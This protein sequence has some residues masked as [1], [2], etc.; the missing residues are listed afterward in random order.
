MKKY[1]AILFVFIMMVPIIAFAEQTNI[2]AHNGIAFG[3][4]KEEIESIELANGFE[5]HTRV[6]YKGKIAGQENAMVAFVFNDEKSCPASDVGAGGMFW[7]EYAFGESAYDAMYD[8]LTT[9][10][11]HPTATGKDDRIKFPAFENQYMDLRYEDMSANGN[12]VKYDNLTQWLIPQGQGYVLISIYNYKVGLEMFAG[13]TLWITND[14]MV[15]YVYISSEY[16]TQYND[17][18]TQLFNDL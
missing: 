10:Y 17:S 12:H 18:Q 7:F 3:M 9:K 6:Q 14:C 5:A 2:T 11:G 1:I 16:A 15:R 4:N 8:V 13:N